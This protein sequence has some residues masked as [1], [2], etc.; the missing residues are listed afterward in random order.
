MY[1]HVCQN[2]IVAALALALQCSLLPINKSDIQA[3]A[4]FV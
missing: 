3:T 1:V 2:V 4:V